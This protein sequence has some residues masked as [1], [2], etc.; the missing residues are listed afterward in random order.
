MTEQSAIVREN[1]LLV[2][3][4]EPIQVGSTAWYGWLDQASSFRYESHGN[5]F[6]ARCE[7]F[8]RGGRYWRAY[9]RV[10]GKLRRSYLGRSADLS[11]ERMHQA[12]I[13]LASEHDSA[14]RLEAALPSLLTRSSLPPEQQFSPHPASTVLLESK[15]RPPDIRR[16]AVMRAVLLERLLLAFQHRLLLL[17]TPPG[18][19]KTTLL[20]QAAQLSPHPGIAWL[21][22]DEADNDPLRFWSY[23]LT[24]LARVEPALAPATMALQN[25]LQPRMDYILA[26]VI[27]TLTSAEQHASKIIL[28]LDDYHTI[29]EISI[30]TALEKLIEQIPNRLH[31]IIAS[32]VAPALPLAR[33]RAAGHV[34]ELRAPDL[35]FGVDEGQQLLEAVLG[36]PLAAEQ[37]HSLIERTEGWAAG[38]HLAGLALRAEGDHSAASTTELWPFARSAG[39]PFIVDYL[40][41]EILRQQSEAMQSFLLR[42]A[43][44]DKMCAELCADLCVEHLPAQRSDIEEAQLTLQN[45]EQANMF[46]LALDDQRHWF[47]Y[48]QLF[49]D[50]LRTHLR[51]HEPEL[52]HSLHRQAMHWYETQLAQ[53]KTDLIHA[54]IE[55]GLTAALYTR[56]AELLRIHGEYMLWERGETHALGRWLGMIPRHVLSEYPELILL[57][58]WSQL[59]S[60]NLEAVEACLRE[61]VRRDDLRFAADVAALRSFVLRLNGDLAGT[62]ELAYLALARIPNKHSPLRYVTAMNLVNTYMLNGEIHQATST[63]QNLRE[64][65]RGW[66]MPAALKLLIGPNLVEAALLILQGRPREAKY[67]LED[68]LQSQPRFLDG[69]GLRGA[70]AIAMTEVCYILGE[71]SEAERWGHLAV[72][73]GRRSWNSD[74]LQ[75]AYGMLA[76]IARA[77][78]DLPTS[79]V[80]FARMY[81]LVLNYKVAH[82]TRSLELAVAWEALLDGD[83][84]PAHQELFQRAMHPDDS[85]DAAHFDE[86]DLM[87]RVAL[88]EQRWETAL[89][90]A[91]RLYT[92]A[93]DNG[94]VLRELAMERLQALV[95]AGAG[96]QQEALA[97]LSHVVARTFETGMLQPLLEDGE[98]MRALLMAYVRSLNHNPDL[99]RS[100]RRLLPRFP[101]ALTNPDPLDSSLTGL[102]DR[103]REVLRLVRLGH[104]NRQIAAD[105]VVTIATVKKH[106]GSIFSKLGV[107]KRA[108]LL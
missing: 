39:H 13:Q 59:V 60:V 79:K 31:I 105:M 15:L 16:V 40:T 93:H 91:Q 92:L 24:A 94:Y 2:A 55:H 67:M 29:S 37:V 9:R 80:M 26:Q 76:R 104:S 4:Q 98:R 66:A 84:R 83:T 101:S 77:K 88:A 19:G 10:A 14:A 12:A 96:R 38:L 22:L 70:D 6:S 107:S 23:V 1:I 73:Q 8:Q 97:L 106:L 32:R 45:L 51:Q 46:V 21:T 49:A 34:F 52:Y 43:I 63:M 108:E 61:I 68:M 62:I 64:D 82:I 20:A 25:T 54:A 65:I 86:Y 42:T 56:V 87:A 72:E 30:H 81:D 36:K 11:A 48:H 78:G 89:Q 74:I 103:E 7:R 50:A 33:W 53:G 95:L 99:Q 102:T 100:I 75:G 18:W 28:V 71:L 3:G 47:R 27:N 58:A 85:I 35:R 90:L 44:L 17:V 5:S 57:E 69:I 41:S